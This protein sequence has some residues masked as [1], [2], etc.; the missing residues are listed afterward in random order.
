MKVVVDELRCDAHGVCVSVCPEVFDL[1]DDDDVVRLIDEY[2]DQS[3]RERIVKAVQQCPK[4][5]ITI[6]ENQ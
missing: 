6:E 5:A 3:L 2:P 1:N 4:A